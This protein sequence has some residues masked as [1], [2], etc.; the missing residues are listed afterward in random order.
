[1]PGGWIIKTPN[2]LAANKET[3]NIGRILTDWHLPGNYSANFK[4]GRTNLESVNSLGVPVRYNLTMCF[5]FSLALCVCV[6]VCARAR[7]HMC[8]H[9]CHWCRHDSQ[10]KTLGRQLSQRV[11]VSFPAVL[12]ITG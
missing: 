2:T 9:V 11:S 8:W 1:M 10:K 12:T 4:S 6:C 5:F 3:P 7:A